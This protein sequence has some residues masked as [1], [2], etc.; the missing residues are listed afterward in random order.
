MSL[1]IFGEI[2]RYVEGNAALRLMIGLGAGSSYFDANVKITNSD[3]NVLLGEI[4]VDKNSW[5]LGGGIASGQTID[6]FMVEASEKI[7]DE[8]KKAKNY[9]P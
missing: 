3:S 5:V 7:A 6:S 4:I 9:M 2:V 8:I 1:I